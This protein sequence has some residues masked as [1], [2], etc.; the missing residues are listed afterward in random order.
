MW[1][2]HQTTIFVYR[3]IRKKGLKLIF[4]VIWTI[5]KKIFFWQSRGELAKILRFRKNDGKNNVFAFF[6]I[7]EIQ[8]SWFFIDFFNKNEMGQKLENQFL[9]KNPSKIAFF[10]FFETTKIQKSWF[11]NGFWLK[12]SCDTPKNQ[13]LFIFYIYTSKKWKKSWNFARTHLSNFEFT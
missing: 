4:W 10:T 3:G 13:D 12:M 9:H 8:K 2:F 1:K 11:F 6:G 5:P 7:P